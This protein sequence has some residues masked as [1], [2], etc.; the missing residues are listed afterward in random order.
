[1]SNKHPDF[2]SVEES[3]ERERRE[4]EELEKKRKR[5]EER[6][7]D[8]EERAAAMLDQLSRY[9]VDRGEM[10]ALRVLFN[11]VTGQAAVALEKE[12][13]GRYY[14]IDRG[15]PGEMGW[16]PY[17]RVRAAEARRLLNSG[18]TT[19]DDISTYEFKADMDAGEYPVWLF[20]PTDEPANGWKP[21]ARQIRMRQISETVDNFFTSVGEGIKGLFFLT[22]GLISLAAMLYLAYMF[23]TGIGGLLEFGR[24]QL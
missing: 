3:L 24:K 2:E 23:L 19:R 20:R 10:K 16:E 11:R 22:L 21:F 17:R 9:I 15:K 13:N 4:R 12:P 8:E 7:V 1:V 18:S 6:L 5:E 14:S